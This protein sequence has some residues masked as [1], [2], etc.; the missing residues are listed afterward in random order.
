[1]VKRLQEEGE[2]V[3]S[4]IGKNQTYEQKSRILVGTIGKCSVGFDHPRLNAM[5]LASD[6]EQYF[7]QYLGRVFRTQEGIPVIFDILDNNPILNKHFR[8]RC[9]T[10]IE[11]GGM[12]KDFWNEF[13]NFE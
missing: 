6:V 5:L 1:L 13:P 10:Y 7:V 8:T 11:H 12:V 9:N 3:T 4:L 2:D